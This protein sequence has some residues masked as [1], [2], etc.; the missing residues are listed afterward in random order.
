MVPES[1][2]F[3]E[4]DLFWGSGPQE[5]SLDLHLGWIP[6]GLMALQKRNRVTVEP[7]SSLLWD[8]WLYLGSSSQPYS[9]T[10]YPKKKMRVSGRGACLEGRRGSI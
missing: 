7:R 8:F 3:Q 9:H 5:L 6:Q 10:N 4:A 1:P 2:P